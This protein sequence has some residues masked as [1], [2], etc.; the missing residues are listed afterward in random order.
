MTLT[1]EQLLGALQEGTRIQMRAA[2]SNERWVSI[3][4]DAVS[5]FLEHVPDS[6][7][8][9]LEWRLYPGSSEEQL[10]RDLLRRNPPP[11]I[12]ND[13]IRAYDHLTDMVQSMLDDADGLLAHFARGRSKTL[14]DI[15]S[16]LRVRR[17]QF[18][19]ILKIGQGKDAPQP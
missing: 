1:R 5:D 12:T 3:G 17:M 2:G 9:A 8:K 19:A 18:K 6:I 4:H 11:D 13:L 16:Q 7:G 14:Q 10:V 15:E